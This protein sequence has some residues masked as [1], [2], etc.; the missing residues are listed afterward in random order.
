MLRTTVISP[1]FL[2]VRLSAL[3]LE[4][5]QQ[6]RIELGRVLIVFSNSS[7]SQAIRPH[8]LNQWCGASAWNWPAGL[9]CRCQF[10]LWSDPTCHPTCV[11]WMWL[12]TKPLNMSDLVAKWP[13]MLTGPHAWDLAVEQ[14]CV[15][16]T[17]HAGPSYGAILYAGMIQCREPRNLVSEVPHRSGSWLRVSRGSVSCCSSDSH[18]NWHFHCSTHH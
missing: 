13:W 17:L 7:G 16:L 9:V 14:P 11:Y 18:G 3:I 5:L 12:W 8:G 10:Q 1:K 15:P 2:K 6:L 4:F